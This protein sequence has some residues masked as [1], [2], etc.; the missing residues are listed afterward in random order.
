MSEDGKVW[1]CYIH[2]LFENHHFRHAWL[3]SLGWQ[4]L[5]ANSSDPF[6]TSLDDVADAMEKS[7]DMPYLRSLLDLE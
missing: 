6:F 5:E 1:G 4:E 7:L 3:R 2:G